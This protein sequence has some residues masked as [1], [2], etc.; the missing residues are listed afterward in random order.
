M[1][2]PITGKIRKAFHAMTADSAA[3][4]TTA[5][6]LTTRTRAA[7]AAAP[8]AP[9]DPGYTR[10]HITPL[11]PDLLTVVVPTAALPSARNISYHN[12]QTFPEKRYGFVDLPTETAD[13]LRRKLNGAVLKGVKLRVEP[14]RQASKDKEEEAKAE[15][16]AMARD[17]ATGGVVGA[18]EGGSMSKGEERAAKREKK[19][20]AKAARTE[21]KKKFRNAQHEEIAGVQLEPGR[22]VRRGWTEP[23]SA[24]T[25]SSKKTSNWSSK[26]KTKGQDGNGKD[27]DKKGDA[28][29]AKKKAE[30]S[31]YTEGPECLFKTILPAN[32][33]PKPAS[34]A[35]ASSFLKEGGEDDDDDPPALD[36]RAQK[37]ARK[38]ETKAR[39]VVVHEFA[40]WT[41]MPTFLKSAPEAGG[42]GSSNLE[43]V[44]GKGWVDESTGTVVQ[45]LKATRP[46]AVKGVITKEAQ[47]AK[48]AKLDAAVAARAREEAGAQSESETSDSGSD[49]SS[50]DDSS[51]EEEEEE[52]VKAEVEAADEDEDEES[53][54][55]DKQVPAAKVVTTSH[56]STDLAS[57]LQSPTRPRSSGSAK[58]LTIK[59]PPPPSYM[60]PPST[61][62]PS[63]A[64][65]PLEALYKR[66]KPD[67]SASAGKKATTTTSTPSTKNTA[68]SDK[69]FSFFGG[70]ADDDNDDLEKEDDVVAGDAMDVDADAL[71]P[72]LTPFARQEFEWRN[73]RSAAPTPD[74]AHPSRISNFK[75][76]TP[77][78]DSDEEEDDEE[79]G[80]GDDNDKDEAKEG[81]NKDGENQPTGEGEGP[82]DFQSWFWDNR[83]DL[84][85]SWKRRRKTAAKDK[86]YREN[87][88]RA[89]RAI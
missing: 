64:V 59:I 15:A 13:K 73:V 45:P 36:E 17:K 50:S 7:P 55:Q 1:C 42:R 49:T 81:T 29:T 85:R 33:M 65:H 8:L 32:K 68:A 14:A 44:D 43:Y 6:P 54:E 63:K 37:R 12:L 2:V 78:E 25:A 35:A 21:K 83:G 75:W 79:D 19:L 69:P 48:R 66:A 41:R 82:A 40:N 80:E 89:E 62:A 11:D 86:R 70:L 10:L 74:T 4:P 88:A 18:S 57:E 39:E 77:G 87:R 58:S 20:A 52:V 53:E 38:Q 31:E 5:K 16:E 60:Q 71:Q 28:T 67:G 30:R 24:A 46:V 34:T 22:Q 51:S 27:S 56:K 76:P 9:A 3:A 61:P 47:L 84:N 72:P 26:D 23:E